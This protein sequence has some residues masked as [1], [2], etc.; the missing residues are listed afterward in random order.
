MLKHKSVLRDSAREKSIGG[1]QKKKSTTLNDKERRKEWKEAEEISNS[2]SQQNTAEREAMRDEKFAFF[3]YTFHWRKRGDWRM[4]VTRAHRDVGQPPPRVDESRARLD[5][6]VG[7][8]FCLCF[9][10]LSNVLISHGSTFSLFRVELEL[11]CWIESLVCVW[12]GRRR[13]SLATMRIH[14]CGF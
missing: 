1:E 11:C 3:L 5:D 7:R 9:A 4:S 12:S 10:L 14:Y 8:C 2:F 6:F 13:R